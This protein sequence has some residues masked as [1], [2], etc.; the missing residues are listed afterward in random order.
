[1]LLTNGGPDFIPEEGSTTASMAGHTDL[2]VSYT[3]RLAFEGG[4][5]G[6]DYGLASAI[7]TTIFILVGALSVVNLK[8]SKMAAKE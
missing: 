6:N 1:M 3:Y 7:A 8:L 4:A 5:G 2:L